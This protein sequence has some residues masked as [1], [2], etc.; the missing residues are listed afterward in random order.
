LETRQRQQVDPDTG[1][2]T[3]ELLGGEVELRG[4]VPLRISRYNGRTWARIEQ[5]IPVYVDGLN[6]V[7]S[8]V[9]QVRQAIQ[10][11]Y[12]AASTFVDW[13]ADWDDL[14]VVRLDLPRDFDEVPDVS[15]TLDGLA[16]LAVPRTT[17]NARYADTA[18]GGAQSLRRG[19][20]R[21][22]HA[23][24]YD[25]TA[26][27]RDHADRTRDRQRRARLLRSAADFPSRVRFEPSLRRRLLER[28]GINTVSD[29]AEDRLTELSRD[30]FIRCRFDATVGGWPH[31]EAVARG[32][33]DSDPEN[34][35]FFPDVLGTL[36]SDALG[37]EDFCG[38]RSAKRNRQLARRWGL[39]VSDLIQ[40]AGSGT[41]LDYDLARAVPAA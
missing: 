8:S 24:L 13:E 34:R 14:R 27:V 38:E 23:T 2:I 37:I 3:S 35:G 15:L 31:L 9:E 32:L 17:V 36:L 41:R 30:M 16:A 39:N 5:S 33:Q 26:E 22:W 12:F 19:V 21:S 10:D 25:K 6:T 40:S 20:A 28:R 7:A 29:L 18:R 11:L 1:E 4:G